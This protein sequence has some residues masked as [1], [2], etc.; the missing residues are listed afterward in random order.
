VPVGDT[1]YVTADVVVASSAGKK[2]L[3]VT[4]LSHEEI[5]GQVGEKVVLH[6]FSRDSHRDNLVLLRLLRA[7]NPQ[8]PSGL[9]FQNF[10]RAYGPPKFFY[11]CIKCSGESEV[12]DNMSI[13]AFRGNGGIINAIGV[14]LR[15]PT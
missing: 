8:I 5:H 9:S 13:S 4:C 14:E 6:R 7:E 10:R 1:D 15:E 2:D 11:S 12:V 3:F